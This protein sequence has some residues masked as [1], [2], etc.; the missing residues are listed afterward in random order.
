MSDAV[1]LSSRRSFIR[2]SAAVAVMAYDGNLSLGFTH[3]S[4]QT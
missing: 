4:E 2:A 3:S 1:S